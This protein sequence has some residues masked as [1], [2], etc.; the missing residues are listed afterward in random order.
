MM[1]STPL[2]VPPQM[3]RMFVGVDL[4]VLLLGVLAP[5]LRRHVGDGALEH[6]EQRLLDA[7]ARH[8]ARDRDV[9]HLAA[10]L[11]DLVDVDDAALARST[12]EVGGLE[13]LEQEV[14]DVLADVARLGERRGVADG[15]GDVQHRARVRASSVLPLP[16][17]PTSR[18]LDFLDLD[19]VGVD[20][21]LR[22]ADAC[23]GCRRRRRAPSWRLLADDVFVQTLDDLGSGGARASCPGPTCAR[24][25][26]G[27]PLRTSSTRMELQSSTHSL[28]M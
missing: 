6:L 28:Q 18:M 24:R 25:A 15:E 4:D 13:E 16:V 11:V 12:I 27:V 7:L 19:V 20:L 17:G 10:D 26:V 2:N 3:K 22:A 8:V 1:S 5:A 21:R 23:S 9:H 14:L